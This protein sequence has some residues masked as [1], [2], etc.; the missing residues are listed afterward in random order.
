MGLNLTNQQKNALDTEKHISL[1]ANAGSGKTFVL[2]NRFVNIL[3]QEGISLNNIVAIT[4]T[5]KAAAKLYKDI[6]EEIDRRIKEEND[7]NIVFTLQNYRRDLVSANIS[8]IHSFCIQLLKEFSTEAQIDANFVPVDEIMSKELL[9]LSFEAAYKLINKNNEEI[10][11]IIKYL[12]RFFGSK[13]KVYSA[14]LSMIDKR[15]R[16]NELYSNLLSKS[17]EEILE[18]LNIKINQKFTLL[19]EDRIEEILNNIRLINEI[20][21]DR[22][23]NKTITVE[24]DNILNKYDRSFEVRKKLEIF[25]ELQDKIFT[26]SGTLKKRDYFNERDGYIS[27]VEDIENFELWKKVKGEISDIEEDKAY[28]KFCRNLFLFFE[29]V[30]KI[31]DQKKE[32]NNFLDFE[33]LLLKTTNIVKNPDVVEILA[34]RYKYIMIDEYQDTNDT[35]YNIFMPILKHLQVNNLFVVGDEKQSIYFFRNADLELFDIT[36]KLIKEKDLRGNLE[37]THSFRVSPKIALFTN[38][39]FSKI[40]KDN[41][42]TFNE[43]NYT[44]LI[45]ARN[46]EDKDIGEISILLTNKEQ[47]EADLVSKKIIEMMLN[48]KIK[49]FSDVAVLCREKG[50]FEEIE[51]S[52]TAHRINYSVIGGMGFYQNQMSSD[53]FHFLSFVNNPN[54]DISLVALL[55]SPFISLSDTQIALISLEEGKTFFEKLNNYVFRDNSIYNSVDLINKCVRLFESNEPEDILRLFLS[56]SGYWG[57]LASRNSWQQEIA[58]LEKFIQIV[59]HAFERSF[60]SYYDFLRQLD[61]YIE[62]FDK[63]NQA[64]V[65]SSYP[66]VKIMTIHKSKGLEFDTVILYNTSGNLK[67]SNIKAKDVKF[68]K[69]FGFM[70]K[71]PRNNDYTDDY[72][73]PIWS[74]LGETNIIRKEQ[75]EHK[76]VFYVAVT[77]AINNLII[78]CKYN[79]K[80]SFS[81]SFFSYLIEGIHPDLSCESINVKGE[82][83]YL[84]NGVEHCKNNLNFSINIIKELEINLESYFINKE[85]KILVNEKHFLLDEI[86]DTPKYELFTASKFLAYKFCPIY[87]NLSYEYSYQKLMNLLNKQYEYEDYSKEDDLEISNDSLRIGVICHEILSANNNVTD[88]EL[89]IKQKVEKYLMQNRDTSGLIEK[90]KNLI[91]PFINSENYKEVTNF[92]IGLKEY[93]INKVVENYYFTGIIDKLVIE[94]DKILI[95]DYKTNN[96]NEQNINEKIEYYLP[97]LKF[98]SFLVGSFFGW[99]K[100]IYIQLMFLAMPEYK[101]RIQVH[102]NEIDNL[103]EELKSTIN[104]IRGNSYISNTKN[105]FLCSY[106]SICKE[107]IL[108]K[109]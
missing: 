96:V 106:K 7:K 70:A 53:L 79:D 24:V 3:L 43:V 108:K 47:S 75:A 21:S 14:I 40:M 5:E 1:T 62:S 48:D 72:V 102:Q 42:P 71:V 69:E 35:Q 49:S 13:E 41:N 57:I 54:S 76:R 82:L 26:G 9:R 16:I 32:T 45:C 2:K 6:A 39:L 29:E 50:D 77:R 25:K 52:F 83:D 98:Y 30:N 19:Y 68:E 61:E 44:P 74:L 88:L 66:A 81:N 104:N 58:N 86:I 38:L 46:T 56:E 15:A 92:K 67:Y 10:S 105:C 20:A 60:F 84:I 12:V 93:E 36:K 22:L 109:R 8:T 23:K 4:F 63:E 94:P 90:V 89:S 73:L 91:T 59:L 34:D 17:N 101:F 80:M 27:I 11:E 65:N 33:D 31:Y 103:I 100:D 107:S 64:Q 87:Y 55:R 18:I 97:Q 95:I 78:S 99:D 28:I 51:K 37:L 85:T